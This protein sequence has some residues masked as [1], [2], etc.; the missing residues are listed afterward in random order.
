[1]ARQVGN[2][3]SDISGVEFRIR[4]LQEE[5][6]RYQREIQRSYDS[7]NIDR[8][9]FQTN[10]LNNTIQPDLDRALA[11][12]QQLEIELTQAKS[13]VAQNNA[14]K[15]QTAEQK[16]SNDLT[17][18]TPGSGQGNN[19]ANPTPNNNAQPLN[20]TEL[21]NLKNANANNLDKTAAQETKNLQRGQ[22]YQSLSESNAEETATKDASMVAGGDTADSSAAEA[23]SIPASFLYNKLHDFTGYTYKI[24]LF[25]LTAEDYTNLT[26]KPNDFYPK[27]ALISS[28]GGLP[29]DSTRAT[30]N[31]H[32]DFQEDFYFDNFSLKTVVGLNSRSKSS[33]I[34]EIKFS[35]I[36]P[37]GMSLLDRLLS[38][39]QT[40]CENPNYIDQPYL[41]QIDFLSNPTEANTNGIT[42]HLID[43]KRVAI[44]F[45][46]FKIKPGANGTTYSITA[47]PY[48]HTAFDQSAASVP[49]NL[50]VEAA[51][52]GD[53]FDSREELQRIFDQSAAKDEERIESEINKLPKYGIA[54]VGASGKNAEEELN[55]QKEQIR[56]SAFYSTKSFPAAYNTYYKNVAYQEG[57]TENPLFQVLF[58]IH[59]DIANSP[60]IDPNKTDV[61]STTMNDIK[62]SV[63]T[64]TAAGASKDF[65][66][67]SVFQIL[68]GT[69]IV[70]LIDRV[71]SSSKY[72]KDQIEAASK[73]AE[74]QEQQDT[75]SN[76]SDARTAKKDSDKNAKEYKQTKWYKIIP[77]ITLGL[78]D[79]KAKAYSKT[80]TYTI[81][82]Y[83]TGNFYH[84]DFKQTKIN[85][86]KCVRTYNYYYTGLNQDILQLDVDFDA[87]YATAITTFAK[88]LERRNTYDGATD[89]A[90]D[91]AA[92]LDTKPSWLP[93]RI[94]VTPSDTQMTGQK[95]KTAEDAVVGSVARSLYSSYPRGDMLNIKMR[96]VGDPAFI[97]QDDILY[98]PISKD[99]AAAVNKGSSSDSPA[100]NINSGQIIFDAEEVYVQ[101]LVKGVIDIDDTIGITNKSVTLS[102]GQSTNGS[103]SGIYRVMTVSSELS[104]G[105]FEQVL[106]LIRV[107]DDLVEI[108]NTP[109]VSVTSQDSNTKVDDLGLER[110]APLVVAQGTD[111]FAAIAR[112]NPIALNAPTVDPR[113]ITA[114]AQPA[115]NPIPGIQ[116][117]GRPFEV[118]QPIEAYPENINNTQF[119]I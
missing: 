109:K 115:T 81:L 84:P 102:N 74:K 106:D 63:K 117:Q 78:Y 62:S 22:T 32:P 68:A 54:Y 51:T 28:G 79:N 35:I 72:V 31:W 30:T 5:V 29:A 1:M 91:K 101:L 52:V 108:E 33:N 47:R 76:S 94:I 80:I 111:R 15:G 103:F 38:V 83:Q 61:S 14:A 92:S 95:G 86:K 9:E 65:K 24:S 25:L 45:M 46:E 100:V 13:E 21:N 58:N 27:W 39:C 56:S 10:T 67:K 16:A 34:V 105:K 8:A 53:Y 44:K 85:N 96:I 116:I 57:R 119:T 71:V 90:D 89:V 20:S 112:D 43:R 55:K 69:D 110:P 4:N 93:K 42:G 17:K 23:Q 37:Y 59:P 2:I 77:T 88:Q 6:A 26:N 64:G 118:S 11:F 60:I 73:T 75:S 49:V 66:T 107:P 3:E 50:A 40:T 87:T 82:P 7:G 114:A 18:T 36:E 97:K 12:K 48:N 99:Y 113:L 70:S 104:R 98:Q 41:L 19:N